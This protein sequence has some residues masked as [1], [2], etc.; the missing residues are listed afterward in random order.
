MLN[1]IKIIKI[2]N[3]ISEKEG[4][5]MSSACSELNLQVKFHW[6]CKNMIQ[7]ARESVN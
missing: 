2:N 1:R 7:P 4:I 3:K 6:M 5:N